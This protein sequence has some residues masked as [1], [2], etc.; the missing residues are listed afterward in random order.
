MS[1][2]MLKPGIEEHGLAKRIANDFKRFRMFYGRLLDITLN[3]RPAVYAV[4]IIL[5]L[6]AIPMFR[7]SPRNWRHWRMKG[8]CSASSMRRLIPLL[9]LPAISA[10]G[11]SDISER[12]GKGLHL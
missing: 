11:G 12:S 2:K 9:N 8:R 5:G 7:M 1:S 4:W 3:A 6:L 10:S